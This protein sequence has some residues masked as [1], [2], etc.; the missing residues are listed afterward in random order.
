MSMNMKKGENVKK[1]KQKRNWIK[2]E[3]KVWKQSKYKDWNEDN[4][5][6]DLPVAQPVSGGGEAA[7][8]PP[9]DTHNYQSVGTFTIFVGKNIAS[10]K[11]LKMST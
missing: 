7:P 1:R 2:K 6:G 11:I 10:L 8:S 3:L 9:T 4:I 5:F